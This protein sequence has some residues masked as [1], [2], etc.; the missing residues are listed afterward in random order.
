MLL[1]ILLL[2]CRLSGSITDSGALEKEKGKTY[3]AIKSTAGCFEQAS[4]RN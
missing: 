1:Q 2:V 3:I 4:N